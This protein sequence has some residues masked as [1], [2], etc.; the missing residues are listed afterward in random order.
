MNN[1]LNIEVNENNFTPEKEDRERFK[2]IENTINKLNT[3]LDQFHEQ[4]KDN[5]LEPCLESQREYV[6][7]KI[8]AKN[9]DIT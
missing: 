1:P 3:Q 2:K 6:E 9:N 5:L 8:Q 4:L 7:T